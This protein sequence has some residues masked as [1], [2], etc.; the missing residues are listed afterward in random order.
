MF[1]KRGRLIQDSMKLVENSK[2]LDVQL[3]RYDFLLENLRGLL[4]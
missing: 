4:L 3:T 1:S 2:N